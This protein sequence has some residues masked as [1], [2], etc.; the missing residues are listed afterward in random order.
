M[1]AC[2]ILYSPLPTCYYDH[3]SIHHRLPA[4]AY[5]IVISRCATQAINNDAWQSEPIDRER[6][7]TAASE[8][9]REGLRVLAF[10]QFPIPLSQTEISTA[11]VLDG[12]PRLQLNCLVAI[13]DPPRQ[14]AIQAVAECKQA[15]I[16]VKMITGDHPDTARTIGGW[17]GIGTDEVLT[18]HR[19]EA[20]SDAELEAH[21]EL[22]NIY[23]R[24]SPEHKLRIVRALQSHG[25]VCSM[26]GD[27]E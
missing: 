2:C 21:V 6:W 20:M 27:G 19:L 13:V 4:G 9:S 11:D 25:K 23:A 8:Y 26:T 7:L 22:C 17:I 10:A 14:E 16:V 1:G 3:S 5:D 18:G 12:Q 15:G 24:A